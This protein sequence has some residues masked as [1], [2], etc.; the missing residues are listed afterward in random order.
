[1][2]M[3]SPNHRP[4]APGPPPAACLPSGGG[5]RLNSD[6]ARQK[7]AELGFY[8]GLRLAD[9]WAA[10]GGPPISHWGV[11]ARGHEDA[12]AMNYNRAAARRPSADRLPT[13][14]APARP[15]RDE[16]PTIGRRQGPNVQGLKKGR[17][18]PAKIIRMVSTPA[19]TSQL[20]TSPATSSQ[21]QSG[22]RWP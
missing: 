1:M 17:P 10:V 7:G 12:S 13:S 4:A 6:V 8:G 11:A 21:F 22:H 2:Q 18:Q 20:Q 19:D 16:G 9:G 14:A 3:R 15:L 5:R